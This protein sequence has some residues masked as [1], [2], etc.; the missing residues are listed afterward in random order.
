[1]AF[2]RRGHFPSV[3]LRVRLHYATKPCDIGR[4]NDGL[5]SL[6]T[7]SGRGGPRRQLGGG[8]VVGGEFVL[9][10][11]TKGNERD[12]SVITWFRHVV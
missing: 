3:L 10:V 2:N 5:G 7:K 6:K 11:L 4:R 1:M 12:A 8:N 9:R